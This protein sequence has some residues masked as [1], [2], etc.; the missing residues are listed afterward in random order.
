MQS[1]ALSFSTYT[2]HH[3]WFGGSWEK[4]PD[5]AIW[6]SRY[7][8][9]SGWSIEPFI[10]A[11]DRATRQ[12]CWNPVLVHLPATKDTVLFYKASIP[13][14]TKAHRFGDCV[15]PCHPFAQS[16]AAAYANQS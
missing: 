3:P 6:G 2:L 11:E 15:A 14:L 9:S 1:M 10:L 5:V 12:P 7:N 13:M 16:D 8:A 4:N